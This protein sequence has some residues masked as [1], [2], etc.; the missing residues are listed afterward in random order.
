[1]SLATYSGLISAVFARLERDEDTDLGAEFI[2]L[3]EARMNRELRLQR[4]LTRATAT[5]ADG[6]SAVP[7]D[8][9]APRSMRLSSS[10][11]LLAFIT[12]EQMATVK[13][14]GGL[15]ELTYYAL[16]GDEFEYAPVPD[17]GTEVALTYYQSLPALT[18]SNTT[19]WLL[20]A[21]PDIY[22]H[23][24]VL[25]GAIYLFED[26]LAT[27][28]LRLF[29]DAKARLMAASVSDAFAANITPQPGITPI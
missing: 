8:F 23:G 16:V 19:N 13:E 10:E 28:S 1:M 3:A 22:L 2:A 20:T 27:A 5:I 9:L 14:A 7:D 25:E 17:D 21:H 6:F 18:D 15:T 24:A 12:P 29:E 4:M 11:K 26:A